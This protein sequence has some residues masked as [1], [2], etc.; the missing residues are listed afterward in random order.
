[1][2]AVAQGKVEKS[3][4]PLATKYPNQGGDSEALSRRNVNRDKSHG[5]L[6]S[7]RIQIVPRRFAIGP[8]SNFPVPQH[9]LWEVRLVPNW[10]WKG[11]AGFPPFGDDG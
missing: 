5:F 6:G 9:L 4:F 2:N 11:P 7:H 1:M 10:K 3:G 8:E